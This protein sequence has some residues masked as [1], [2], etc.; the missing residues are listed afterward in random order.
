[1]STTKCALWGTLFFWVTFF[2]LSLI[3]APLLLTLLLPLIA[4]VT[5]SWV[6]RPSPVALLGYFILLT[7]LSVLVLSFEQQHRYPSVLGLPC[8][9]IER[10]EHRCFDPEL[11]IYRHSYLRVAGGSGTRELFPPL[12]SRTRLLGFRYFAELG[13]RY[14]G[15]YL[16][17]PDALLRLQQHGVHLDSMAESNLVN[18]LE[19]RFS[20]PPSDTADRLAIQL[21]RPIILVEHE[22]GVGR[23]VIDLPVYH[24][25]GIKDDVGTLFGHHTLTES[26]Y[27]DLHILGLFSPSVDTPNDPS[28]RGVII[29]VNLKQG[30][31]V[32][33]FQQPTD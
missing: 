2:T 33:I 24:L 7:L 26:S 32:D 19:R 10:Q 11:R 13:A 12:I 21:S 14:D 16:E 29:L 17:R 8:E 28:T 31:V 25:Q 5:F 22:P 23:R 4:L 3:H 6:K 30:I 9:T 1:M 20:W 27:G 18:E 15:P